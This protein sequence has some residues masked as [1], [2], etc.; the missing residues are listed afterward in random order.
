MYYFGETVDVFENGVVVDQSGSWLVGGPTEQSDP[1]GTTTAE[2]PALFMPANPQLHE[3]FK[4]ENLFPIVDETDKITGVNLTVD[5]PAG[6]FTNCI[7]VRESSQLDDEIEIKFYAPG[8]G[9]IK[10]PEFE[11]MMWQA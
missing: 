11:L 1:P 3:K 4:P 5:V 10:G 6:R 8:V 9:V 2:V 7:R